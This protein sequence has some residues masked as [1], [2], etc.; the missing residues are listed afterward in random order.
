MSK[1]LVPSKVKLWLL[2]TGGFGRKEVKGAPYIYAIE[3]REIEVQKVAFFDV[4]GS[5]SGTKNLQHYHEKALEM[6]IKLFAFFPDPTSL[7]GR[8]P[9][10]QMKDFRAPYNRTGATNMNFLNGLP[11]RYEAVIFTDGNCQWP[12]VLNRP[13]K[14]YVYT[15][16]DES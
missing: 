7:I 1:L 8:S 11:D 14:M 13:V 10:S 16:R 6:G 15:D 3:E 4:S 2:P 12:K 9:I 5:Q